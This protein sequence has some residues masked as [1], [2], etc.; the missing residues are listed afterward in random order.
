MLQLSSFVEKH[1]QRIFKDNKCQTG[2]FKSESWFLDALTQYCKSQVE[3]IDFSNKIANILHDS[4]SISD[5]RSSLIY[6]FLIL[7]MIQNPILRFYL[8]NV[9]VLL[10]IRSLTK[11]E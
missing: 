3:L 4:I 9:N 1:I 11:E 6:L 7:I 2:I 5:K 8:L 10:R